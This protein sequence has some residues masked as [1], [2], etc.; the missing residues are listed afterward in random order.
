ML[1]VRSVREIKNRDM[2]ENKIISTE[3]SNLNEK[4]EVYNIHTN[5]SHD[6]M[7]VEQSNIH[8]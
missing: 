1:L 5:L 8:G 4:K 3:N 2:G 7:N 6:G